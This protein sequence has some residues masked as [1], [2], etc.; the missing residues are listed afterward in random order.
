MNTN[1]PINTFNDSTVEQ[2]TFPML[3]PDGRNG[4]RS[5]R[6]TRITQLSFDLRWSTHIPYLL[7]CTHLT[8]RELLSDVPNLI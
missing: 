4:F 2:L 8:E 3:F 5:P 6:F 1:A 7:W